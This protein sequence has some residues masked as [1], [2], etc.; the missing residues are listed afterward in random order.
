MLIYF[1]TNE[2]LT[3]MKL[4]SGVTPLMRGDTIGMYGRM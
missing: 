4:R 1:L 3:E 2:C